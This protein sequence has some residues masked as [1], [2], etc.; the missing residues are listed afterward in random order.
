M[1]IDASSPDFIIP[2]VDISAYLA[3]PTSSSAQEV[4]SKLRDSC[5]SSGFFQIIRHGISPELQTAVLKA[6]KTFF[7]YPQSEKIKYSGVNGRGYELIG[8]QIL[9]PGTK[10]ELKE[11]YSTKC[12]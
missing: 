3:D 12:V 1:K 2:T 9:E 5:K 8:S 10:P 7:Q 11:V 4:I 6:A